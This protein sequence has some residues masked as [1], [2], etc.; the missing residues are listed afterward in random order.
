[1]HFLSEKM[2]K[3]IWNYASLIL[4]FIGIVVIAALLGF[5]VRDE[6]IRPG[7]GQVIAYL[8]E[9]TTEQDKIAKLKELALFPV[10]CVKWHSGFLATLLGSFIS[11]IIW[12][13]TQPKLFLVMWILFFLPSFISFQI[14]TNHHNYHGSSRSRQDMAISLCAELTSTHV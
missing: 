1:M 11:I 3:I 6:F 8:P 7:E 10:Y 5:C 9:G 13:Q 4:L 14:I 12:Y 2:N